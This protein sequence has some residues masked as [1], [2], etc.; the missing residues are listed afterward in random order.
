[1]KLL[2]LADIHADESAADRLRMRIS[3]NSYDA[4]L[5][6]GD[7]TN[8]GPVS[9]VQELLSFLDRAYAVHG[10]MDPPEVASLLDERGVSIHAKRVSL[11]GYA[12]V[13]LGGSNPT[14]FSTP[15][16]YSEEEIASLLAKLPINSKTI[17]MTHA[18]PYG[19]LDTVGEDMHVG[20][21]SIRAIIEQKQ[22][23]LN[24]CGHIHECEGEGELGKTKVVKLGAAE[25]GRAAEITI[26]K[27]VYVKFILL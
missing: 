19:L 25:M 4:V 21:Q 20:S 27:G 15:T 6:A 26:D 23:L 8:R 18:P 5:I 13:G 2:A 22:P 12:I 7:L 24:I 10:N 14:P 1:M 16:E 11:G 17:L 3:K 9:F